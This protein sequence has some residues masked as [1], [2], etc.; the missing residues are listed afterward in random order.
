MPER[1]LLERFVD[2]QSDGVFEQALAELRAGRKRGHWMW[3]IFPQQRDLGRSDMS[4]YYGLAGASE[5]AAYLD[6][7][8]LG[9]RLRECVAVV[10]AEVV[11]GK[12]LEAIFGPLDARKFR[13]SL[14]I[15]GLPDPSG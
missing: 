1:W 10:R 3:F 11:A 9:P 13:S 14:D 2:A 8:L 15:F 4:R 6:H 12:S 7:P 5:A